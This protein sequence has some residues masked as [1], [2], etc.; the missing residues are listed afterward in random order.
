MVLTI[1]AGNTRTK[2]AL[3][4][5]AGNI[6]H[7]GAC[8]NKEIASA[9]MLPGSLTCE[10][11]VISNVAGEEHAKQLH[12]LTVAYQATAYWFTASKQ[13]SDV[14]NNYATPELLGSDRWAALIAA[15]HMQH[16]TCVVV[17]AGTATTID[18]IV[19]TQINGEVFGVFIG[20]MILPGID[21]MQQ[22]LGTAT[23]Q[24]PKT[25]TDTAT[26]Q[27]TA[28]SPFATT[29]TNAI[30][31]GAAHAT[32]GAI[33]HMLQTVEHQYGHTPALIISGGNAILIQQNLTNE[34]SAD[35]A[36]QPTKKP[37]T[38]ADNLVL[39]GLYLS[40]TPAIKQ[41]TQSTLS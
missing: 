36:A 1:D 9:N 7:Q 33:K 17:N 31:S 5:D 16:E 4:D 35:S 10:Q 19:S 39:Q 2:W 14:I 32:L 3:F 29:T 8:L 26:R 18:A 38:I 15:W 11:I 28:V 30:Y 22:S 25:T 41:T 34:N 23:A 6:H 40:T 27:Q 37:V 21:I 24:L 12:H 20:G 13:C